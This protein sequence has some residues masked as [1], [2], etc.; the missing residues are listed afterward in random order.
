VDVSEAAVAARL[1]EISS[2]AASLTLSN[3][4]EKTPTERANMLY[5]FVKK[6]I[7]S[8]SIITVRVWKQLL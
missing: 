4:L 2:G 1:N 3:D 6:C 8:G 5:S 7:S